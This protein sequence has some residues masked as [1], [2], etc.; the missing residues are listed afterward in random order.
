M[1]QDS[2]SLRRSLAPLCYEIHEAATTINELRAVQREVEARRSFHAAQ[3]RVH[4]SA[5]MTSTRELVDM[6]MVVHDTR[7]LADAVR[8][9]PS[10][11]EFAPRLYQLADT[12]EA[13]IRLVS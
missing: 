1:A 3:L 2:P 13:A 5:V 4:L 9:C 8:R 12:M 6:E 10:I 11:N 7:F